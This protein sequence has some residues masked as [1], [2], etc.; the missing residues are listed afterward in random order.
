M[1]LHLFSFSVIKPLLLPIMMS[2]RCNSSSTHLSE[3]P[4]TDLILSF[5][6]PN[7]VSF[8]G[9]LFL[10]NFLMPSEVESLWKS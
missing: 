10:L 4:V 3:F 9:L 6:C 8:L 5:F 7:F 1:N 2:S